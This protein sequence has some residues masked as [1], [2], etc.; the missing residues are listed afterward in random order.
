MVQQTTTTQ[1]HPEAALDLE[2]AAVGQAAPV[3]R[4]CVV[5]LVGRPEGDPY[6]GQA[7]KD[8]LEKDPGVQYVHKNLGG[9][10]EDEARA[11]FEE[12]EKEIPEVGLIAPDFRRRLWEVTGGSPI[13]LV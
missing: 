7:L 1:I 12:K 8:T 4:N 13:R 6:L 10:T 5:L 3:W 2:T 9:F 11:Y